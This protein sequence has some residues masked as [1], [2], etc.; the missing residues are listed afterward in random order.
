VQENPSWN[1]FQITIFLFA[2]P[3]ILAATEKDLLA[4]LQAEIG[5]YF[6]N[7]QEELA[8]CSSS[9]MMSNGE[10]VYSILYWGIGLFGVAIMVL[11]S[12][13]TFFR[14]VMR[15]ERRNFSPHVDDEMDDQTVRS[16]G[17]DVN[18]TEA[19]SDQ[20]ARK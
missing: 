19:Q 6:F 11:F 5:H 16:E 9:D 4:F 17:D 10:S 20:C 8:G 14:V 12:I 2:I 7:T 3:E 18:S 1:S 13:F 15:R